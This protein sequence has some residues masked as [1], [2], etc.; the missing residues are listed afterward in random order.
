MGLYTDH[1]TFP[2]PKAASYKPLRIWCDAPT[3]EETKRREQPGYEWILKVPSRF[4]PQMD[5][6][7]REPPSFKKTKCI[8]FE[9][10]PQNN[11]VR[12]LAGQMMAGKTSMQFKNKTSQR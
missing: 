4:A 3:V 10:P 11:G 9:N 8:P 7:R 12:F 1:C 2:N 6:F 5:Q